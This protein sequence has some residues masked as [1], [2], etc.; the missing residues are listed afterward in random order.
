MA[1]SLDL[2]E[3]AV[4]FVKNGRRVSEAVKKHKVSESSISSH[5][6]LIT[7]TAAG[8]TRELKDRH[9]KQPSPL[10]SNVILQPMAANLP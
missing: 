5:A 8:A 1:Y 9:S 6:K 7:Y 3:R 4:R 2:R 10:T